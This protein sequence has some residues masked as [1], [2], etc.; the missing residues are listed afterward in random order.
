MTLILAY[1]CFHF[2]PV[3]FSWT[4]D[5][6]IDKLTKIHVEERISCAHGV[7]YYLSLLYEI[8]FEKITQRQ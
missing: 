6:R 7:G 5:E 2:V 3:V 8:V 1:I 4:M